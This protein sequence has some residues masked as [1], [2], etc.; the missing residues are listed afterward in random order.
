MIVLDLMLTLIVYLTFPFIYIMKTDGTTVKQ[1]KKYAL[2][3]SVCGFL[4][5]TILYVSI[6][7]DSIAGMPTAVLYYYIAKSMM[8]ST[9]E[10]KRLKEEK[11]KKK[12]MNSKR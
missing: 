7:S 5:F 3:N 11:E 8:T 9:E 2:I 4:F 6:G 10:K 1:A 12:Q